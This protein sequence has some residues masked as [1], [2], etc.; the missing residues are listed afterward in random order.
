[1]VEVLGYRAKGHVLKKHVLKDKG[2]RLQPSCLTCIETVCIHDL[3]HPRRV[4]SRDTEIRKL[5]EE[6]KGVLFL[7]RKYNLSKRRIYDITQGGRHSGK[8]ERL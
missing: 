2:C 3:P 5:Y 1:M 7:T 8:E 4:S 6:G